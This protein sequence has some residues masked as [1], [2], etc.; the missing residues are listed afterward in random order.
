MDWLAIALARHFA[1]ERNVAVWL[2][3]GLMCAGAD[4]PL[5][6]GRGHECRYDGH[7]H[8]RGEKPFRNDAA[9]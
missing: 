5:E 7:D 8:K 4:N 9:L 2:G 1:F 3:Q 6:Q